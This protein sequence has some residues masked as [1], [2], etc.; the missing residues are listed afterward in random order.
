[1]PYG[2][3]LPDSTIAAMIISRNCIIQLKNI[4]YLDDMMKTFSNCLEILGLD[5]DSLDSTAGLQK[6]SQKKV[7]P[8][9]FGLQNSLHNDVRRKLKSGKY[10][11]NSLDN[12]V[13]KKNIKSSNYENDEFCAIILY[14]KAYLKGDP[15]ILT[16]SRRIKN[17][18]VKSIRTIGNC[19][20]KIYK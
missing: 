16:R 18:R 8:T 12:E 6:G 5:S 10:D 17:G 14:D 13:K 2:I 4:F 15:I 3:S 20:W 19:C 11:Q 7:R 9:Y 1:M